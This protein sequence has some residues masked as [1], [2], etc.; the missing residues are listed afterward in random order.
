MYLSRA[1][2]LSLREPCQLRPAPAR[3]NLFAKPLHQAPGHAVYGLSCGP[4]PLAMGLDGSAEQARSHL[5]VSI[6][7]RIFCRLLEIGDWSSLRTLCVRAFEL[8][9]CLAHTRCTRFV[10]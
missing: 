2:T 3:K 9:Q 8:R 7:R 1:W 6:G 10:G 5:A 4:K